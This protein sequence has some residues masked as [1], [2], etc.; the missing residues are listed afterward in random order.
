MR[1]P[2]T[3]LAVMAT[4]MAAPAA[5]QEDGLR[6]VWQGTIG[7]L[8]VHACFEG[9]DGNGLYYYDR[10]LDRLRLVNEEGVFTEVAAF[11]R[12]GTATWRFAEVTGLRASGTWADGDRRLP[13]ALQRL[14]WTAPDD[15]HG[16]CE[17]EA[18]MGP[19]LVGS[20]VTSAPATLDGV[21]YTTLTFVPPP[22]WRG[23]TEDDFAAVA[24]STF[25][26]PEE[27]WGDRA[28]NREL[29]EYLPRGTADDEYVQCL[30]GTIIHN[31][32]D[33]DFSEIVVPEVITG[34][35]LGVRV[36][37]GNYCGGAHPNYWEHRRVFD[38]QFGEEINPDSWFSEQGLERRIIGEGE[39]ALLGVEPTEALRAVFARNW[40]AGADPECRDVALESA[41]GWDI[42]LAHEGIA[43]IPE[44]PHVAT[45]CAE[46][47]VLPWHEVEPFMSGEGRLLL[48]TMDVEDRD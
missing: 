31:G 40:P 26:L 4:L 6:G 39:D 48:V 29:A 7:T 38:R 32:A 17:A 23:N 34:R 18:F 33:G 16:P 19:L 13:I 28:I 14:D 25:A 27:R 41:F 46:T 37:N 42:G 1:L 12:E 22:Q 21:T 5:A 11:R 30:A 24:I 9:E 2:G 47:V 20:E 10:Y 3:L 15:Y 8:P 35:W 45:A 43:V 44:L 36:S